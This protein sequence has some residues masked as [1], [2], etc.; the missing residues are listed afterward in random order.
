MKRKTITAAQQQAKKIEKIE[1]IETIVQPEAIEAVREIKSTYTAAEFQRL[2]AQGMV[3]NSD[4][5]KRRRAKPESATALPPMNESKLQALCVRWFRLQYPELILFAIPNGGARTKRTNKAGQKFSAE[6]QRMKAEGVLA[7]VPDLFLAL[8]AGG[9]GGLW[10]EMKAAA[11]VLSE[12]QQELHPR[13]LAAGYA[14][15][16]C[17]SFEAFQA[18]VEGYLKAKR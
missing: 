12:K 4:A 16:T 11:G 1:K 9:F 14:L 18:A 17:Y 8:P 7:G 6:A 5:K 2:V 13:L 10:L 3:K 15:K